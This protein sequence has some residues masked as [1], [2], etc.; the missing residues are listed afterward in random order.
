MVVEV[1]VDMIEE[2]E[3]E[4]VTEAV[5][6][7]VSVCQSFILYHTYQY[8]KLNFCFAYKHIQV[9]EVDMIEVEAAAAAAEVVDIEEEMITDQVEMIVI[10]LVHVTI[11]EGEEVDDLEVVEVEVAVEVRTVSTFR[12]MKYTE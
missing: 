9:V 5:T 11:E 1:E 8:I 3:V 10:A 2:A 4:A 12:P 7:E 6:T